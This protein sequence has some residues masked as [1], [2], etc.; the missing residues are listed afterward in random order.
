MDNTDFS[1]EGSKGIWKPSG[2]NN[3]KENRWHAIQ[4]EY[5]HIAN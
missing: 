3:T 1:E 2:N 5:P 4:L